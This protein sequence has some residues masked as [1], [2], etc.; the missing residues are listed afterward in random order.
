[1]RV[2][3]KR[4]T[5]PVYTENQVLLI[6]KIDLKLYQKYQNNQAALCSVSAVILK[7]AFK[8]EK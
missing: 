5:Q 2:S 6:F 1:M 7:P 4:L 3:K 8:I